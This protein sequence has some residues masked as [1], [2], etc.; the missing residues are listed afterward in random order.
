MKKIF[1][2]GSSKKKKSRKKKVER[3]RNKKKKREQKSKKEHKTE[4]KVDYSE[5][6]WMSSK[7]QAT[8]RNCAIYFCLL[9]INL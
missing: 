4:R 3:K 7:Q 6:I 1:E 9:V 8:D 2:A 5:I